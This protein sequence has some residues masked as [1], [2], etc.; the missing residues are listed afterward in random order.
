[1][2]LKKFPG[3]LSEKFLECSK[4]GKSPLKRSWL[5][6][7]VPLIS[8]ADKG[9]TRLMTSQTIFSMSSLGIILGRSCVAEP[10]P[11][12]VREVVLALK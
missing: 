2:F 12:L 6:K 11:I 8:T 4:G 5:V 3:E 7:G 10:V 1:M 9:A